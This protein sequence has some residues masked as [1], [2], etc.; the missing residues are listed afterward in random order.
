MQIAQH[1]IPPL[2]IDQTGQVADVLIRH[3]PDCLYI[4][5]SSYERNPFIGP[6]GMSQRDWLEVAETHLG[7]ALNTEPMTWNALIQK[8]EEILGDGQVVSVPR[9]IERLNPRDG[10][11]KALMNRLLDI[12]K[13]KTFCCDHGFDVGK[14]FKRP[15]IFNIHEFSERVQ[16]LIV[17][18]LLAYYMHSHRGLVRW[19]LRNAIVIH[20]SANFVRRD[21]RNQFFF[22]T[23]RECRNFGLGLALVTQNP[24]LAD[25][26]VLSN[27]GTFCLFSLPQNVV[28]DP[29]RAQLNLSIQQRA[30]IADLPDRTMLVKTPHVRPFLTKVPKLL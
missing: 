18:D 27:I 22:K 8:C 26:D 9:L 2:V 21:G 10:S 11:Q 17:F 20:E 30:L 3:L 15:C 23:V 16:Q 13:R 1:N 5:F 7:D 29:L 28:S 24:H 4:D 6:K 12:G 14:M 19:K 25:P